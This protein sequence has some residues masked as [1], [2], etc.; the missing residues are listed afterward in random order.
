MAESTVT[1]REVKIWGL[2]AIVLG[3]PIFLVVS[4]YS[5]SGKG[6]AAAVSVGVIVIAIRSFWDLRQRLW[7]WATIVLVILAHVVLIVYINWS[8]ESVP[9]PALA[10]VGIVDFVII[11]GLVASAKRLANSL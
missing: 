2:I 1:D 5:D 6:R 9:A 11:Y 7:F 4:H 8:S 3:A 10:P